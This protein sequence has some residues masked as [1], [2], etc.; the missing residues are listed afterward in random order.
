MEGLNNFLET[1]TLKPKTIQEYKRNITK[2]GNVIQWDFTNQDAVIDAI[3]NTWMKRANANQ[4][5]ASP[6][7]KFQ[8][9]CAVINYMKFYK[10]DVSKIKGHDFNNI[11]RTDRIVD[12][13]TVDSNWLKSEWIKMPNG[14][15]KL[16]LDFYIN[17]PPLRSD[18]FDVKKEQ[19]VDGHLKWGTCKKTYKEIPNMKL[20]DNTMELIELCNHTNDSE[21][22][23]K[24]Q[25]GGNT[26]DILNKVSMKAFK[27]QLG[28][29]HFRKAYVD[30]HERSIH[31]LSPAEQLP[32]RKK[33]AERMGHEVSSQ[34]TQYNVSNIPLGSSS[35]N[36]VVEP[37]VVD[38]SVV[39]ERE[40]ID[41][42]IDVYMNK[43]EVDEREILKN[44]YIEMI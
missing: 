41:E 42:I 35:S 7:V 13:D 28:I 27:K 31:H 26:T 19:V 3:S 40:V 36:E 9:S 25:S 38:E 34:M 6:A 43:P 18:I 10:L 8:C 39:D 24:P 33:L 1:I 12:N 15:D 14:H 11:Y 29:N 17:Y 23:I 32:I 2:I 21:L 5:P 16:L 20:N 30:N 37:E 4:E 44:K 22:L